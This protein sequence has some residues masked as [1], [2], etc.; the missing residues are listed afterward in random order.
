[1]LGISKKALRESI[2]SNHIT[3]A[4]FLSEKVDEFIEKLRD[5]LLFLVNSQSILTL[6]DK[7]KQALIQSLVTSTKCFISVAMVNS[8]GEEFLKTYNPEYKDEAVIKDLSDSS[9]FREAKNSPSI[10][11]IYKFKGE[12]RLD[13]VYPLGN[14]YI[15]ITV[16]LKELWDRV[17]NI[18]M[19]R[20][21]V[22][23]IVDKDGRV[24]VHPDTTME[25]VKYDIPPVKA[26]IARESFGSLEYITDGKRMVGA[27]VPIESMG[28]GVVTQQAYKYAFDAAIRMRK[29]AYS[30]IVAV[31]F[32][33]VIISRILARNLSRPVINLI[34]GARMV[35]KGEFPEIKKVNTGD[36]LQD[37]SLTFNNMV[38]SLKKFNDLQVDKIINE[39]TKTESI[40]FSIDD[41]IVLTDFKGRLML[42]NERAMEL[43]EISEH[44]KEGNFIIDY[45][46]NKKIRSIFDDVKEIELDLSEEGPRRIIKA[47][48]DEVKTK[49][50]KSLGLMR[51]IRDITLEKEIDEMK[52]RFLHSVTHDLKNPLSAIVGM[53]DLL[54]KNRGPDITDIEK[55]YYDILKN[56]TERLM[57]IINDILDLAKLESGKLRIDMTT[58]EL[59]QVIKEVIETFKVQAESNEIEM[60]T[61]FHADEI[62]VIA[63]TKLIKRVIVNL[64][65]N[66]L[67]H[68]YR[69]GRVTV[70]TRLKEKNAEVCISDT[71]KGIPEDMLGRVF[72]RFQQVEGQSKGGTGI[73]LNIVREI[74]EAHGKKVWV[75]SEFGQGASFTFEVSLV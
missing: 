58:F 14:E 31:F 4:R 8:K 25:G 53:T 70:S 38:K 18:S 41:G 27:F 59:N 67:Q 9:L 1:M 71:G 49:N 26:V 68:T 39:R 35:S 7:G 28:W 16:S 42:V 46:K 6:D 62:E 55:K 57:G 48:T 74:I 61:E 44:P 32:I 15:A 20:E 45:I 64:V 72:D 33:A 73:G 22:A 69:K 66:A 65:G 17:K 19:G 21:A 2:L 23:F 51:V 30:W 29:N 24:L 34:E 13:I 60:N 5:K 63:D 54:K 37:L 50:G 12:P 11:S 43:M 75:E 10:G 52:D 47:I 56:E 3:N 40:I 36:E